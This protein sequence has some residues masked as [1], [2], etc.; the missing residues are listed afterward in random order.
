MIWIIII[1]TL[2][3]FVVILNN[4]R[5]AKVKETPIDVLFGNTML[6]II[7]GAFLLGFIQTKLG[8]PTALDVYRGKTELKITSVNGVPQDTVV[9]LKN[10]GGVK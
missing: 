4:F 6:S 10:I 3:L 8:V 9:V 1:M 5:I 7:L 2:L